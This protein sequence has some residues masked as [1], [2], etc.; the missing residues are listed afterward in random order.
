MEIASRAI[1][2][3]PSLLL[4]WPRSLPCPDV[5]DVLAEVE[6]TREL[7]DRANGHLATILMRLADDELR[8]FLSA[9]GIAVEAGQPQYGGA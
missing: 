4:N 8:R 6:R 3:R 7:P 5:A 2:A 1:A 9:L